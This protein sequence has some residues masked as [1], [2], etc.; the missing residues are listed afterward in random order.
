MKP[1]NYQA[2]LDAHEEDDERCAL[3]NEYADHPIHEMD[4]VA[5]GDAEDDFT[6][7]DDDEP[8]HSEGFPPTVASFF[9][10]TG[11]SQP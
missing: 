11:V 9:D 2:D 6:P 4:G 7:P 1:H 3:C 5:P 10:E 8:M